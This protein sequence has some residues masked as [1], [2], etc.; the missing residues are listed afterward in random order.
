METI[1]TAVECG[2]YTTAANKRMKEMEERQE[3]LARQGSVS[4]RRYHDGSG[5]I[6]DTYLYLSPPDE[7]IQ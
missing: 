4:Q 7:G 2:S 1:M 6:E 3:E 5:G